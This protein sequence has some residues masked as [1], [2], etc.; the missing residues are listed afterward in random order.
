MGV[1][2]KKLLLGGVAL[3]AVAAGPAIAADMPVK[4]LPASCVGGGDPYQ[5]Y[6]CLDAYLGQDFLTRL[7]NY[8]RLEWGKDSAPVDP[9]APPGRI[10]GWPATP[11]TT[12]PY[13]FTEWPY[14][15]ATALGVSRP[16][17]VDSPL[18]A[19]LGNTDA[20]KW[21]SDN[22]IQIYGWV[23]AGANVSTNTTRPGGNAP[24]SY[25]Y[26]PNTGELDQ[27]VV[28]VERV[29][30]TV[31]TDHVDWGF[32]VSGLYGEN[33]RYTEAYGLFS[34]QFQGHNLVNG[35][36][37]P[38]VY[39]E[40]YFPQVAQGL[41]I[42]VGRFISLPDIEAQLAP[43]N[44]M[45]SHSLTY[46][47]DNYTNT[48]IQS[49]LAVTKNL[50]LQLGVTVGTEAMPW[51]W[52]QTIP[53]PF[54]N[55]LYPGSTMLK[56]PG[57]VPSISGCIRYQTDSGRD[58]IYL[59]ADAENSGDWG[60]NN[61]QWYGLTY[62]H[63]FND[64]WHISF[65]TY[66]LGERNVPNANN[67]VVQ[68]IVANGGTPFANPING[69]VVNASGIAYNAP[70]MAQCSD[71]TALTYT[72]TAFGA[73][74]YL[75]YRASALDNISLRSEFYNDMEG[76]RTGT[77]T[78]YVDVGLGWQHWLS[79]QI[80]LRPEVDYYRSLDAPA[81]NG[82]AQAVPTAI[83]PTKWDTWF[84]AADFIFHF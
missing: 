41:L 66:I 51:H 33:Y 54:P 72:A 37:A 68:N 46:A 13:P 70:N 59:C 61:L 49:T 43:N 8:Y 48:G 21:L 29:P 47:F 7:I 63:K 31:Q 12:P 1:A 50:F 2:M 17:S 75:N 53:N 19:A 71:V 9:D 36:D 39:G 56:D 24:I 15:G 23:N 78:R 77:K 35:V 64:Q 65:E 73:V 27:A 38:M 83:A 55:P 28:Y 26:T 52:G 18:M 34:W 40:L 14:G 74:S 11:E 82:N 76:Q 10:A 6:A 22:H 79:P 58:N 60:F 25:M 84:A 30:D 81:F 3:M 32:R 5:N 57:A 16:N 44:Y 67:P 20:G 42:R 69:T 80:E 45:Y 62:Y 4:A